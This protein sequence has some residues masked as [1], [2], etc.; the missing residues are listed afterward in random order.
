MDPNYRDL[1]FL[2]AQLAAG[3]MSR[4]RFLRLATLALADLAPIS[5]AMNKGIAVIVQSGDVSSGNW[6]SNV[7]RSNRLNGILTA[8]WLANFVHDHSR[9]VSLSGIAGTPTANDRYAGARS[10]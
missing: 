9:Y 1:D 10:V 6:V 3:T 4:G 7:N 8:Q 5:R 2:R